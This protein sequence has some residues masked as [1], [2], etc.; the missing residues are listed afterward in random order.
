MASPGKIS[1]GTCQ[2]RRVPVWLAGEGAKLPCGRQEATR[3]AG[4]QP[5]EGAGLGKG[6]AAGPPDRLRAVGWPMGE[7]RQAE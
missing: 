2:P 1:R 4:L 6:L 3:Q 5:A 7:G